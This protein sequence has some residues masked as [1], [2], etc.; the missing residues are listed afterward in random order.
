VLLGGTFIL[1]HISDLKVHQ[2]MGPER[3]GRF[4]RKKEKIL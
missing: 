1:E 3:S 2:V 4:K